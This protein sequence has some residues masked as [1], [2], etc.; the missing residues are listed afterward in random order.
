MVQA[1]KK[2]SKPSSSSKPL[3]SR[4]IS[5]HSEAELAALRYKLEL[6]SLVSLLATDAIFA[7]V[8]A[9]TFPN[10]L[11]IP[12]IFIVGT[13]VVWLLFVMPQIRSFG[14]PKK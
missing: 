9:W 14:R 8:W 1:A 13:L 5:Q 7:I 6:I 12:A 10:L 2:T 11:W 3:A 4:S